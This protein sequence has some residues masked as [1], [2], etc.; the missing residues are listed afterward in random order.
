MGTAIEQPE[1]GE[2]LKKAR[3]L[4]TSRNSSLTVV[5]RVL[6]GVIE[7]TEQSFSAERLYQLARRIDPAISIST[8]YRTISALAEGNLLRGF[9]GPEGVTFYE[10]SLNH[11]AGSGHIICTDCGKVIPLDTPC[12]VVRETATAREKGFSPEKITL[13]LEASCDELARTG[14]CQHDS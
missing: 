2:F 7:E 5:R 8:V 9:E 11:S 6:C 4:W 12:M 1:D 10:K 3:E 14:K 13:R